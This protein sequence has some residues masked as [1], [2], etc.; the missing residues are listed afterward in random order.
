MGHENG[1]TS[2]GFVHGDLYTV[3]FDHQIICW[4]LNYLED[5]IGEKK[6]MRQAGIESRR[7]EVYWK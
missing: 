3:S 1:V 4:D 2:I 7:F 6:L 5:R